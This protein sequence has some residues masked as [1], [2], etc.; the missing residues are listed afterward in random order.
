MSNN[1]SITYGL[2]FSPKK[3]RIVKETRGDFITFNIQYRPAGSYDW[4]LLTS[5]DS[6]YDAELAVLQAKQT[7]VTEV[8]WEDA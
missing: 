2:A 6:L 7:V 1:Q 4:Y 8:V 3:Y 5:R